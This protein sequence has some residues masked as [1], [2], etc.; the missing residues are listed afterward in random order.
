MSSFPEAASFPTGAFPNLLITILFAPR[1]CACES[2]A[3]R[4]RHKVITLEKMTG[5]MKKYFQLRT[6]T[7]TKQ[8][9]SP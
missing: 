6:V 9:A 5:A 7:P 2:Q 1:W 3:A 8:I 4:I